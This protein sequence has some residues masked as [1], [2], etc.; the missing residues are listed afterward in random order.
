[1][2]RGDQSCVKDLDKAAQRV[3][4]GGVVYQS[5]VSDWPNAAGLSST[6][7]TMSPKTGTSLDVDCNNGA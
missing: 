6:P 2:K 4:S 5:S 7:R 3:S 1:M